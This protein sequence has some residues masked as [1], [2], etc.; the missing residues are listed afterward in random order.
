[1]FEGSSLFAEYRDMIGEIN[2]MIRLQA[3]SV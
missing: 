1:M 2:I 3:I